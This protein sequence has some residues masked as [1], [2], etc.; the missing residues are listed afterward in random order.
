MDTDSGPFVPTYHGLNVPS[1]RLSGRS[2][3]YTRG[4]GELTAYSVNVGAGQ[5]IYL[6]PFQAQVVVV[7][8]DGCCSLWD[9]AFP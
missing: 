3:S 8:T 2:S 6:L 9:F 7:T 1:Q 5:G 4:V